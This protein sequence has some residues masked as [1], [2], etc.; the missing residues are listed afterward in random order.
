MIATGVSLTQSGFPPAGPIAQLDYAG[1]F[2]ITVDI[3][4]IDY[5]QRYIGI[6]GI[7]I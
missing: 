6:L 3:Q 5:N 1:G 2:L 4:S 7:S